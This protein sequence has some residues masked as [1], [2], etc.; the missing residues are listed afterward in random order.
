MADERFTPRPPAGSQ[1]PFT[2]LPPGTGQQ[3]KGSVWAVLA[4]VLSVV[5]L[6]T[7]FS[8]Q[9]TPPR[10]TDQHFMPSSPR[11]HF[12]DAPGP[13]SRPVPVPVSRS[14]PERNPTVYITRTGSH[15]HRAGCQYL[16]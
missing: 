13:A 12:D 15:Y 16:S 8:S 1:P 6:V 10:A 5:L 9:G 2:P 14:S 4:V 7:W 3:P 11:A